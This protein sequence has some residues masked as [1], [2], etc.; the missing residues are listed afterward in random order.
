MAMA[1]RG[2]AAW[3]WQ[4]SNLLWLFDLLAKS[5]KFKLIMEENMSQL[6]LKISQTHMEFC[7]D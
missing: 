5:N 1:A 4:V 6:P 3:R 7:I 2:M